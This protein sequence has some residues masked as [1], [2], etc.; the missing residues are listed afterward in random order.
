MKK[1]SKSASKKKTTSKKIN[2][3]G[4]G[5]RVQR[6]IKAAIEV[7]E[8]A[9]N[10]GVC[11]MD[12]DEERDYRRRANEA[13]LEHILDDE[14]G[15]YGDNIGGFVGQ[16]RILRRCDILFLINAETARNSAKDFGLER[17]LTED[18]LCSI[19]NRIE[20]GLD[21]AW[22]DVIETA[23]KDVVPSSELGED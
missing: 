12:D 9:V 17:E 16:H 3:S 5:A 1:N 15:F 23:I 6:G 10:D 19:Q 21:M 8:E 18:E 4:H 14:C 7:I 22:P 2:I 11:L 20:N 13:I